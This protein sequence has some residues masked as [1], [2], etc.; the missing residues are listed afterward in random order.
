MFI[1]WVRNALKFANFGFVCQEGK[2]LQL[3]TPI[4][5]IENP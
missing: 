4:P 1:V 2:Q 5:T 3:T